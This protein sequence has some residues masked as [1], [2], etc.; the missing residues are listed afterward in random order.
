MSPPPPANEPLIRA[1]LRCPRYDEALN[2][3]RYAQRMWGDSPA[4]QAT[5]AWIYQ[6]Q[7]LAASGHERFKL[8][9]GSITMMRRA[10]P[11]FMAAGG[12]ELPREVLT[13]I[14]PLAYWDLIQQVLGRATTSIRIWSRRWWRR[15]RPSCPTS[16]RSANAVGL[17]QLMPPTGAAVRAP[18]EAA[19]LVAPADEPG[20]E[21]PDG[22]GLPRRQ[23]PRVRRA[24]TWRWP[25]TTPASARCAGGWPSGPD[26][27]DRDEF[28]DDIPYPETQNYVKRILGTAEDYRRLYGSD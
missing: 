3:L 24:C 8:L 13:V 20:S 14:F 6:Q 5:I 21:R 7:G 15:N 9:R 28:I 10:Y 18:A 22:H 12:E 4:I 19:V 16:G 11:Q 23:D 26:V 17:M 25:A 1:L 2:E 27:T